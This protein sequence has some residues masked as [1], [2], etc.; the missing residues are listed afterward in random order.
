MKFLTEN[1]FDLSLFYQQLWRHVLVV[2]LLK[3]KEGLDNQNKA[4]YF[5][6]KIA[7]LFQDN[8]GKQ[9]AF[10]YLNK[11]G[12]TFWS[13]TDERVRSITNEFERQVENE[14]GAG[15]KALAT[16]YRRGEKIGRH[17]TKELVSTAQK[18]VNSVQMRELS[19]I[20]DILD[21]DIFTDKQRKTV[22]VIDDLDKQWADDRIRIKLIE[23]LV[24]ALPKFRKIKNVKIVVAMRDDLL[25]IVLRQATTAGFQRDKFDD[26]HS[27][28]TWSKSEL[29]GF[30]DKRISLLYRRKYTNAQ[31]S[32]DDIFSSTKGEA[33]CFD[34]IIDRTMLRPRDV[35]AY[36]N[37]LIERFGGKATIG[38]KDVRSVELDYSKSRRAALEGEWKELLPCSSELIGFLSHRK[39]SAKFRLGAVESEAI[40][41][42]VMQLYMHYEDLDLPIVK[43]AINAFDSATEASRAE[44]LYRLVALLYRMGSI[45]V[46]TQ[47]NSAWQFSFQSV[48]SISVDELGE[49]THCLVHPMLWQTLKR[50]TELGTLFEEY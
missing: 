4:N 19:K 39:L 38:L 31:V 34:Y 7:D 6:A 10:E 37:L 23:A 13:D 30:I 47:E 50:R 22:L 12:G 48:P 20:I 42:L 46:R 40:D 1:D 15:Y 18:I 8:S 26:Y 3:H 2:E 21:E 11:Y 24:N 49:N 41:H 33:S 14:A 28:V 36:F 9:R 17:E 45:G 43:F 27:R 16:K 29:R 32:M 35:L 5:L 44:F 25:D